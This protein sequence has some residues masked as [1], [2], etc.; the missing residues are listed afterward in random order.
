[1]VLRTTVEVIDGTKCTRYNG[2]NC[3]GAGQGNRAGALRGIS[4]APA[5]AQA[6]A[7]TQA[8]RKALEAEYI[9]RYMSGPPPVHGNSRRP[10]CQALTARGLTGYGSNT[11]IRMIPS[12]FVLKDEV[13]EWHVEQDG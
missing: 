2:N 6:K 12:M 1:M 13:H 5:W 9:R 7:G 4:K 3:G 8:R 10:A 11:S